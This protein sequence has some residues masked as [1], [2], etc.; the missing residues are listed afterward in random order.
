MTR[1]PALSTL[2]AKSGSGPAT[3]RRKSETV[4][5]RVLQSHLAGGRKLFFFAA[6]FSRAPLVPAREP[7]T[8]LVEIIMSIH[9]MAHEARTPSRGC[10]SSSRCRVSSDAVAAWT[11]LRRT[12]ELSIL[13]Y[14]STK[15][16]LGAHQPRMYSQRPA[17]L[18]LVALCSQAT[19]KINI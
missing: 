13:L 4:R 18:F 19:R 7:A 15:P 10:G 8:R 6:D 2:R 1:S 5:L 11:L 3:V 14:S 17:S 16:L 9:V 12:S